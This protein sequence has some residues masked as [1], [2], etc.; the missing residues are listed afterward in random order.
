MADLDGCAALSF[1]TRHQPGPNY[2]HSPDR[3]WGVKPFACIISIDN[4]LKLLDLPTHS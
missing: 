3:K 4:W 1:W 2:Q